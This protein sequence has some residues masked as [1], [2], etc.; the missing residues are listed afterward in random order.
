MAVLRSKATYTLPLKLLYSN[1]P[2]LVFLRVTLPNLSVT[3]LLTVKNLTPP[4]VEGELIT[5]LASKPAAG[6]PFCVLAVTSNS[7][8]RSKLLG[9]GEA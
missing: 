4:S 8:F 3:P 5:S 7:H 1:P 6:R 9:N 2:L